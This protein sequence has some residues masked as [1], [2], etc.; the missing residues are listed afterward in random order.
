MYIDKN[1]F[2]F[3]TQDMINYGLLKAPEDIVFRLHTSLFGLSSQKLPEK[4]GENNLIDISNPITDLSEEHLVFRQ[5][6]TK[7]KDIQ[8]AVFSKGPFTLGFSRAGKKL[9]PLLDDLA[10]I[11][12]TKIDSLDQNEL[13]KKIGS[14]NMVFVKNKGCLC[15]SHDIYELQAMALV[16]E[17]ACQ[18]EIGS[19]FLGGGKGIAFHEALMMN[20]H[21]RTKYSKM[22]K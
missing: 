22:K 11:G 10:Q 21:Y 7:R 12:G 3:F 15:L 16:A 9:Y 20:W 1:E 13:L 6:F 4:L 18:A 5:L 14:R 8:I 17:K 19:Y 2:L